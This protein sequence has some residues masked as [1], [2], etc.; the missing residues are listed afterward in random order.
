MD[1]EI[2]IIGSGMAALGAAYRLRG[3]G[4]GSRLYEKAQHPGG[5]TASWTDQEGFTFDEG[6]HI[7]FT[8]N[9]RIKALFAESVSQE[10]AEKKAVMNN[11]WQG[12][13]I[14]HPAQVN[15]HGL[16]QDLVVNALKDFSHAA[17]TEY[18][19]INNYADWLLA[20]FGRTF[21]ETFPMEYGLKY[22]TTSAENMS[23]DW[24]GPRILK[25]NLEQVFKGALTPDTDDLHYITDFRY[26]V[27]NG[28]QSFMN[29][30]INDS[31]IELGHE[32]VELDPERKWLRFSNGKEIT[33]NHLISSVPLPELIPLIA[34]VPLEVVHS[35][36]KLACS[37][38]V[39][40]NIGL[41]RA[42]ISD[43]HV[44]Y[45]YDSD[46]IFTRLS[47]PHM[48]AESNAPNGKGSIQA[49]LYYSDKYKPLEMTPERCVEST[50][51]DLK[52]CGLIREDDV[53]VSV[54]AK[55]IKYANIIFDLERAEAVEIV[56]GYLESIN[57]L[58]C[59]R[60][61]EWGYMWTDESFVS[62][63]NAAQKVLNSL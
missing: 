9:D 4:V 44:S 1:K 40:V 39:V 41:D 22:H 38:C 63:E 55:L 42:D 30:F 20:S 54:H 33:Y 35:V 31:E 51:N 62:G 29:M 23:T 49:E 18:G 43:A 6:P 12:H 27:M 17:Y 21:A 50:I 57:V 13:W 37:S 5:H 58:T 34:N 8:K 26:P 7:S 46:F 19:E 59:G 48:Q 47:F 53:I 2:C 25:P 36:E 24:L 52:R 28:F 32:L 60:Y 11:Y 61:G 56:K 16:P 45:F 15:L 14:K 10:Y 3:E